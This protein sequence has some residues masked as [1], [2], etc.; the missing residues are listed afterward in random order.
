[1]QP[2]QWCSTTVNINE[3]TVSIESTDKFRGRPLFPCNRFEDRK[4]WKEKAD[5]RPRCGDRY[6]GRRGRSASTEDLRGAH[7]VLMV[8]VFPG[9]DT[10]LGVVQ[11]CGYSVVS[12]IVSIG[13]FRVAERSGNIFLNRFLFVQSWWNVFHQDKPV[14]RSRWSDS[15]S[16]PIDVEQPARRFF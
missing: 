13:W 6:G 3:N 2:L 1:M 12:V 8:S 4:A 16:V 9:Y 14:S 15:T 5:R 10:A 7:E 11:S